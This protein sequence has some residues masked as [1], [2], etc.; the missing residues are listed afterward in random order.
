MQHRLTALW[1]TIF[2][3]FL[4]STA[5]SADDISALSFADNGYDGSEQY[6]FSPTVEYS[7]YDDLPDTL[8]LGIPGNSWSCV[9]DVDEQRQVV[10][11]GI[12]SIHVKLKSENSFLPD[13]AS[14]EDYENSELTEF[15][16]FTELTLNYKAWSIDLTSYSTL[17]FGL[18]APGYGNHYPLQISLKTTEASLQSKLYLNNSADGSWSLIYLDIRD[19]QGEFLE[20]TV[21]LDYPHI[22]L[23]PYIQCSMPYLTTTSPAGFD[24][25][26]RFLT[27]KMSAETGRVVLSNGRVRPE[28][29]SA[30]L[31]ARL[32]TDDFPDCGTSAYYEIKLSGIS[33]GNLTLGTLYVGTTEEQR[34]FSKRIS[35]SSSDGVYIIPVDVYDDIYSFSLE[36]DNVECD[37]LYFTIEYIKLYC[38]VQTPLSGNPNI[39][40]VTSIYRSGDNITFTGSMERDSVTQFSGTNIH[41]YAI[42]GC[43]PDAHETAIEIG[44]I[45]VSTMFENTVDLSAYPSIGDTFMFYAAVQ[46]DDGHILPLSRPRYADAAGLRETSVSNIGLYNAATVGAFESNVSHV[47]IDLPLDKLCSQSRNSVANITYIDYSETSAP[48]QFSYEQLYFEPEFLVGLDRDIEFYISAG[49]EVYLQLSS[50]SDILSDASLH[51]YAAVIRFLSSR[52]SGIAGIV[53]GN[54]VNSAEFIG[55]SSFSDPAVYAASLAE[56]CRVTYN[57]ASVYIPDLLVVVPFVPDDGENRI[58]ER[59]LTVMLSDRLSD[60]GQI[61]WAFMYTFYQADDDLSTVTSLSRNLSELDIEGADAVMFFYQPT[62]NDLLAAYRKYA[63]SLR[64]SGQNTVPEYKL[65]VASAFG[66]ICD[67]CADYRARAVF[68]SLDGLSVRNDHDFYSG[69]KSV[70]Q[71]DRFVYDSN[72]VMPSESENIFGKYTIWNFS[73][74]YYP[75]DWIAGGGVSSCVTESSELFSDATGKYTR[76][77]RSAFKAEDSSG[78]AGI[79]LRNFQYEYDFS[80]IERMDFTFSLEQIEG[81]EEYLSLSSDENEGV[82]VVFVI[83]TDDYRAEFYADSLQ[84]G[85]IQRL[86]CDLSEYKYRST[87]DFVG[88]MVY[89]NHEVSFDLSSVA[90]SSSTLSDDELRRMFSQAASQSNNDSLAEHDL[91]SL[92]AFLIIIALVTVS[93]VTLL[94]RRDREEDELREAAKRA[95]QQNRRHLQST[96]DNHITHRRN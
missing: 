58:S 85:E 32:I 66:E 5:V 43:S 96:N 30:H 40:A 63:D 47:M 3:L 53:I 65:Y 15:R 11:G 84:C 12:P 7:S 68:L 18:S 77:L 4:C 59:S 88:I 9:G 33:Q 21:R 52:Y 16:G 69:L 73:S 67:L 79:I 10:S 51:R 19:I 41:F 28:D 2:F 34:R 37:A 70:G 81:S 72:A 8:T 95:N 55:G 45:K 49:I 25:A 44:S 24:Y 78:A 62:N 50:M 38:G 91:V 76:V 83:G 26:Q 93:A 46:T 64:S 82:T 17:C 75:L 60:V 89:A 92:G 6:L 1:L 54:G 71:S 13:D 87:V 48:E 39:G 57:A 74:Q 35:L 36:F 56:I 29:G 20:L 61:P 42:P 14:P 86:S 22:A 80:E 31:H 27:D 23:P 94:T 90:V